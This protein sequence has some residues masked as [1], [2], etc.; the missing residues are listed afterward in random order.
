MQ[1]YIERFLQQGMRERQPY[2]SSIEQLNAL[3]PAESPPLTS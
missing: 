3:F 2:A 1:P